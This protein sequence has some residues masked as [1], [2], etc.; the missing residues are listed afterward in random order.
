[1]L[2]RDGKITPT[3]QFKALAN[4]I[5]AIS[6]QIDDLID[7]SIQQL[8]T[9]LGDGGFA[10]LDEYLRRTIKLTQQTIP[11]GSAAAQLAVGNGRTAR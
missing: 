11:S 4:P 8:H 1:M 2:A 3:E 9:Q 7:S 6:K 5:Q 10:Q